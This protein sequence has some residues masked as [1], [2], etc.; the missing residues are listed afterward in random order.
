MIK[1][2]WLHST[3]NGCMESLNYLFSPDRCLLPN[4]TD[5]FYV[6]TNILV[7]NKKKIMNEKI[8]SGKGSTELSIYEKKQAGEKNGQLQKTH[9]LIITMPPLNSDAMSSDNSK[10]K[11]NNAMTKLG[12]QGF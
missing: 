1:I 6:G 4:D 8:E 7:R 5:L 9:K 11:Q 3:K 2:S 12:R 10:D